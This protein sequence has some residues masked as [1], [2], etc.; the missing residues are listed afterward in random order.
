VTHIRNLELFGLDLKKVAKRLAGKYA[1]GAS[2]VKDNNGKELVDVQGDFVDDLLDFL[3][4]EYPEVTLARGSHI[5]SSPITLLL[6]S[7]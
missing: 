6:C 2:V 7:S 4:K 3:P 1:C 5:C